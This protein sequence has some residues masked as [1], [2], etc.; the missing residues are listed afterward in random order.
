M[1]ALV[2]RGM[3]VAVLDDLSSGKLENISCHLNGGGVRFVEGD[4]RNPGAVN[5]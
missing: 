3:R 5:D 4:V 1:D 2:K